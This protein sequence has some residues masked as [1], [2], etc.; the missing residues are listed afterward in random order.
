MQQAEKQKV[1]A[2]PHHQIS[3]F[4]SLLSKQR[5]EK[6]CLTLTYHLTISPQ[7]TELQVILVRI[8]MFTNGVSSIVFLSDPC[9]LIKTELSLKTK[10]VIQITLFRHSLTK[11]PHKGL[12]L[13]VK[14]ARTIKD[15]KQSLL[16]Q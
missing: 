8:F 9:L 13:T 10:A 15:K 12:F 1:H 5:R 4:D 11:G 6:Q 2:R 16:L 7:F 3:P 14:S